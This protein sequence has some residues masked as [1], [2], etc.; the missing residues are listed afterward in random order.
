LEELDLKV[1]KE[2]LDPP[3]QLVPLELK[4]LLEHPD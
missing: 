3:D 4:E 1:W 2:E